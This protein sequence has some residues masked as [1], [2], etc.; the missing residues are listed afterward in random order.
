MSPC[1]LQMT[2]DLPFHVFETGAT[3]GQ[4]TFVV[5][6]FMVDMERVNFCFFYFYVDVRGTVG[7]SYPKTP[8]VKVE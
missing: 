4:D 6:V 8:A 3:D 7:Q 1:Y 5:E 2:I